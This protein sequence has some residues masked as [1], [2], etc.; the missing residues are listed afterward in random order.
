MASPL[1]KKVQL[2][3]HCNQFLSSRT[4]LRHRKLYGK[5]KRRGWRLALHVPSIGAHQTDE[6][7]V[8]MSAA[9]REIPE[10]TVMMDEAC[11]LEDDP[12][13]EL[14]TSGSSEDDE[15]G[16]AA[17]HWDEA[18]G[19]LERDIT[20]RDQRKQHNKTSISQQFRKLTEFD[21]DDFLKYI[22][23]PNCTALYRYGDVAQNRDGRTVVHKCSKMM[24][25]CRVDKSSTNH[26]RRGKF[27]CDASLV[28]E[29]LLSNNKTKF[30]PLKTFC[31]KNII[32]Y[33]EQFLSRPD[34][35]AECNKWRN[36]EVIENHLGDLYDGDI[37]KEF[38][39]NRS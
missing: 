7:F 37:W 33:L 19:E 13:T 24:F 11:G 20:N 22:V 14:G 26:G 5:S 39:T 2:C 29:V 32:D 25:G 4:V 34:F 10:D 8:D 3:P 31:Y 27:R 1:S 38:Q 21:R 16:Q 18:E 9:S 17:H 15:D 6:E 23:C 35:E 12:E 36:R 30:Y 28:Q